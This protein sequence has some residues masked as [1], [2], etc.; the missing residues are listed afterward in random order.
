MTI[1]HL[2]KNGKAEQ[3]AHEQ[4]VDRCEYGSPSEHFLM[5]EDAKAA[6]KIHE[7]SLSDEQKEEALHFIREHELKLIEMFLLNQA[8]RLADCDVEDRQEIEAITT[9]I[10]II[11]SHHLGIPTEG[12]E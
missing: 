6:R 10:A 2:N 12:F 3:C 7:S 4:E 11:R 1:Y 8:K 5:P 9:P